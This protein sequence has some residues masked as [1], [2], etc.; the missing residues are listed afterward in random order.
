M[1]FRIANIN[2]KTNR[3][4]PFEMLGRVRLLKLKKMYTYLEHKKW[5][6]LLLGKA[7][8]RELVSIIVG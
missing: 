3:A 1:A 7:D 2:K 5:Q 6:Y 4:Y 8:F